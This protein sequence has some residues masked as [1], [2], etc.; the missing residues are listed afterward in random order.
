MDG[1]G[2]EQ[3]SEPGGQVTDLAHRQPSRTLTRT[4]MQFFS[5]TEDER[6]AIA[7]AQVCSLPENAT[8]AEIEDTVIKCLTIALEHAGL[9]DSIEYVGGQRLDTLRIVH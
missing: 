4:E 2:S 3:D 9:R 5:Y 6:Q 1:M 7:L 8:Y